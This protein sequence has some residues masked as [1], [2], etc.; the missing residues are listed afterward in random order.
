[1]TKRK[2]KT[3][4]KVFFFCFSLFNLVELATNFLG[5]KYPGWKYKFNG[6]MGHVHVHILLLSSCTSVVDGFMAIVVDSTRRLYLG[7]GGT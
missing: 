1:M 4:G 6:M 7:K 5:I 3:N 2:Q